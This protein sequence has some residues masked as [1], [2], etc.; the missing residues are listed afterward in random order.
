MNRDTDARRK[1]RESV[2]SLFKFI[3]ELNKIKQTLIYNAEKG[4][5]WFRTIESFPDDPENIK[6]YYRDRVE[7]KGDVGDVRTLLS[8]HKPTFQSCPKPDPLFEEWLEQGWD[9]YR[10]EAKVR[11]SLL[12]PVDSQDRT[13]K[14]ETYTE[15]FSSD[16]RRVRAYD[17]WIARR[18]LWV[19]KQVSLE[20]TR[21]FFIEL[22]RVYIDLER[23]S[24]TL[25]L[26]VADGFIRDRLNPELD[27]PILTR[28]VK[29]HHDAVANTIYVEDTAMETELHTVI[30]QSME[31]INS[32][33]VKHLRDDLRKND[34]HP[35]DRN[36]LPT[37]LKTFVHQL[38]SESLYSENGVPDDWE[39][40]ERLLLYRK[41]CYILR[42]RQ[43]GAAQAIEQIIELV[44]EEG[45]IP[46]PIVDVV[47]GGK[48]DIP[49]SGPEPT[50]EEQLSAVGGESIDILLSKEANGEQLEIANR[51]E[52][53]NA[54]LV[55]GPPG[56]GKT[57]T[58]ANLV[59]HFLAQGKSVLVTS[60]TRKALS[61]LK[62][63]MTPGL[64]GLC[65][66]LLDDSN[67]DMEKSIDDI[68][69][70]LAQTSLTGLAKEMAEL[71][72]K[73]KEIIQDLA[74]TRRKLFDAISL[75]YHGID[76]EGE[77][78]SLSEAARYVREN[79]QTLSYI[80]GSVTRGKSLPLSESELTELYRSNEIITK[81][82]E[83]EF[84]YDIPSPNEVMKPN[85]F[86]QRCGTLYT[87][88]N[89][90]KEI[91]DE[92]HWQINCQTLGGVDVVGAFGTLKL[93]SAFAG[94][95]STITSYLA[96][97]PRVAP[98]MIHC[99]TDGKRGGHY[100]GN[101]L[102]L[103]GQ[104]EKT[105]ACS[106]Q[107]F[108][109]SFGKAIAVREI[110]PAFRDAMEQLLKKYRQGK[111]ISKLALWLNKQLNIA[112][113][114]AT[115]N[116][117]RP[118]NAEDCELILRFLDVKVLQNICASYWDTLI[119]KHGE[120]RFFNLDSESPES[121]ASNYIPLIQRYIDWFEKEYEPLKIPMETLGIS[122]S[123]IFRC[124]PR[125]SGVKV[126]E[127]ILSAL[128]YDVRALCDLLNTVRTI[129]DIRK[130]LQKN[131]D[132]LQQGRRIFS[133]TCKAVV[134]AMDQFD[135]TAYDRAYATL[136]DTHAK[137]Y[138][139]N[140]RESYLNRLSAVAPQWAEAIR[141]RAGL[142]G[143]ATAP[144]GIFDAW[145][146]KQY[147]ETIDHMAAT[148]SQKLQDKCLIL[149]KEYR[150]A[151]A[152]FAEKS[153]W[154]HLL[155]RT[156]SDIGMRQA[157]L[158]WKQTV[159]KIGKGTGRWA[160]MYRAKAR[161]LMVKC[162]NAVP[163]W[164]MPEG[165]ALE[166]LNPKVNRFDVVIIDEASQSDLSALAIL[167]MGRKLIIV[168]DDKQVSPMAI[169]IKTDKINTLREMYI[170]D[171]IPTDHLYDAKTS[172]YDIAARTF[173][174][175]MLREHFRCVPEIIAFSNWLSYGFNIKPLRD[176]SSS[177]LLP[178]VVNYR[179]TNG[180]RINDTNPNEAKAIVAL[181][182]ACLEQPEYAGKTFGIIS[183]LGDEQVKTLQEE[184]I[185]R[186]DAKMCTE[187]RILCGNAANFQGDERDVIFL[188]V[189]DC[190]NGHGPLTKREKGVD[191]AFKKRYNVATS[192]AKDQLWVVTSLDP[193]TDLKSGDIRKDLI[194]FSLN[195]KIHQKAQIG[196]K[197][198]S[199]FE[200][201][202]AG[203]LVAEG[204]HVVQQWEVGAYWLDMVVV[205][206]ERKIAIECDGDR[207]H[208]GDDK[209]REDMERQTILERLG[210]R[211]IRIRGSEYYRAPEQTMERVIRELS[212][213]GITPER[214]SAEHEDSGQVNAGRNTELLQRV[215][216]R[217]Q[218]FLSEEDV[219]IESMQ[220]TVAAALNT[221]TDIIGAALKS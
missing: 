40:K 60:H 100:K 201:A 54:V 21:D 13:G 45:E 69:T 90:L 135:T 65:V 78:V 122:P 8:V 56:T 79:E 96:D 163:A 217:A 211:F 110:T 85:E 92:H 159:K 1:S 203:C 182:R 10:N 165:K 105:C 169:G 4:Y 108:A 170:K 204:Y 41:P 176:C 67:K 50:V 106:E 141:N 57:H 214:I 154:H 193:T 194:D 15:F 82:D 199:P 33:S 167:Y 168:G 186:I 76:Y 12:R 62:E 162:Q 177:N 24:E 145:R 155:S 185:K 164:I 171:K 72:Q 75:E 5:P 200:A 137:T 190:T 184:V 63:K 9:N 93:T 215:K 116:G 55:Q 149:G 207:Y 36:D 121:I 206:G 7:T 87:A 59:G 127:R 125:A 209:I 88:S 43:G 208:Y 3:E 114:G 38:S 31:E 161:E 152:R 166:S 189:V 39:K 139:R 101:W 129:S 156:S 195:P 151:T 46:A 138:I 187:R 212:K 66:S 103:I 119:A 44:D 35:L 74:K 148:S 130:E 150:E 83:A 181:L 51:I 216:Q 16:P 52:H 102:K 2:A 179:V 17:A 183:L 146:W 218:E 80:P 104:I 213:Q 220:G 53:S 196:K 89:H 37:F 29:I 123:A 27:H 192:R 42:R 173:Q 68:T 131:R 11:K 26:I 157:L 18:K 49:Q 73:R 120:P 111:K 142:H 98:W 48:I 77:N 6:I 197:A 147:C 94:P 136:R 109:A 178:A 202:V 47:S 117:R 70:H 133:D 158:G 115:V 20:K 34:Y 30:F 71:H 153:A 99:A 174:P 205:C 84:G 124:S 219:E 91:A 160:P 140:T 86:A 64:Q 126:T 175:L 143:G 23:D 118:Q 112:L 180:E 210:W 95:I 81:H 32:A 221:R 144:D 132:I 113:E 28:R 58:I 19:E 198:D 188:S 128:S 191:E 134:A 22:Y 172:I 14:G 25:E 97:F 107:F 61:V